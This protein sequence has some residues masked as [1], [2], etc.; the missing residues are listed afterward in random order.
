MTPNPRPRTPGRRPLQG[1]RLVHPQR[2]QPAPRSRPDPPGCERP[3][4]PGARAPGAQHRPAAP[5]AREPAHDRGDRV[6]GLP[7]GRDPVGPQ[8]APCRRPSG[9]DPR[10]PAPAVHGDGGP[11]GRPCAVLR[12]Y[13]RRWKFEV[14][15][16]FDGVGPDSTDEEWAASPPATRSS[17][18]I[19]QRLTRAVGCAGCPLPASGRGSHDWVRGHRRA[20][21]CIESSYSGGGTGGTLAAN[22]LRRALGTSEASV[23]V[24]DQDDRHVYQPGLLFVPFG[25]AHL[26]EIVRSRRRQLHRDI[27]YL[28]DPVDRVDI[29]DAGCISGA[30]R[31]SAT[32]SWSWP[33]VQSSHPRRPRDSRAPVGTRRLSPSTTPRE[34][35]RSPG[36]SS[37]SQRAL[38]S[39]M[40]WRCPS[41]APWRPW[42]SAFWPTGSSS[43]RASATRST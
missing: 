16:F 14:G 29:A 27:E 33:P 26:D 36:R 5:H 37:G 9:A 24:V 6:L 22:R 10:P 4:L 39:S 11:R 40:S 12:A 43:S 31:C 38:S 13:L 41:S 3:G 30:G 20:P 2:L 21:A 19:E 8:R 7:A 1:A 35:S 42:S 25:L 17:C 34:R 28:Q 18:C 23:T 32:T 15:M